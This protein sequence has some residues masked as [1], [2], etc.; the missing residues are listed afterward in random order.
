MLFPWLG[1]EELVHRQDVTASNDSPSRLTLVFAAC[2][3]KEL[4]H[5]LG[6]HQS[7]DFPHCDRVRDNIRI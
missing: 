1:A 7:Y 4:V 5:R 2:V 3:A 6:A